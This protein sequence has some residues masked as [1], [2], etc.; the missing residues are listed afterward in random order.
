MKD[1][2]K[3]LDDL[4]YNPAKGTRRLNT[5]DR[6]AAKAALNALAEAGET[7]TKLS[8]LAETHIPKPVMTSSDAKKTLDGLKYDL[9]KGTR[10]LNPEDRKAAKA[11]LNA[12]AEAGETYSK[13]KKAP[14]KAPQPEQ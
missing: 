2:K 11:A 1:A 3:T 14:K 13:P 12:L 8:T 4:K 7:Y 9:S 6:K 5:E 10:K